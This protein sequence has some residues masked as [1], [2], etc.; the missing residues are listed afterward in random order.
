[1][2]FERCKFRWKTAAVLLPV[3][4]WLV[5]GASPRADA[6]GRYDRAAARDDMLVDRMTMTIGGEY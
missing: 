2:L 3:M 1:M 5:M 4:G 6:E